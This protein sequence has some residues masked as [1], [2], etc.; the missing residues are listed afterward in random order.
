VNSLFSSGRYRVTGN[1]AVGAAVTLAGEASP[2]PAPER[3]RRSPDRGLSWM[4]A[5]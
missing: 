4:R 1:L 3:L 2:R 5:S